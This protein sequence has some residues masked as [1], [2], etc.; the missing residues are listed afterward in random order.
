ML[1]ALAIF[2]MGGLFLL[3]SPKLRVGVDE[4]IGSV[5]MGVVSWAPYSYILGVLLI[6]IAL[7]TSFN[8][9]SQPR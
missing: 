1:R 7:V 2:G 3:I 6:F 8:R 9:G 5:Y 4:A